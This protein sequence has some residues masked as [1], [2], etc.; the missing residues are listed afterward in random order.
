MTYQTQIGAAPDG[1]L[2]PA[3]WLKV[4]AKTMQD[5]AIEAL[6]HAGVNTV[7]WP[8]TVYVGDPKIQHDNGAPLVVHAFTLQRTTH[9]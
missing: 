6:R 9:Q 4:S 5:A 7:T 2:N 8:C 3:G 1:S